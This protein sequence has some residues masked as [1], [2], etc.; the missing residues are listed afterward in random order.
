LELLAKPVDKEGL[1]VISEFFLRS[2]QKMVTDKIKK[3]VVEFGGRIFWYKLRF[4][5]INKN[6]DN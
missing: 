2:E 3:K 1:T 6:K 4:L 5:I